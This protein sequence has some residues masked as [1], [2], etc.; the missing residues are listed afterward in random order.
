[1][2]ANKDHVKKKMD[3]KLFENSLYTSL[4]PINISSF[5]QKKNNLQSNKIFIKL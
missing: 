1:M 3:I 2:A 4:L 5:K